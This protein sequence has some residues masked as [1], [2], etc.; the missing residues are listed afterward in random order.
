MHNRGDSTRM[1]SDIQ[2]VSRNTVRKY[3]QVFDALGLNYEEFK[4]KHDGEL[5]RLFYLRQEETL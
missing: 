5:F 2:G 4:S 3:I 1:I